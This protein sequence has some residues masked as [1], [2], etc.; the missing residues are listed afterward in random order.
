MKTLLSVLLFSSFC[1]ATPLATATSLDIK[2]KNAEVE[3]SVPAEAKKALSNWNPEFVVFNLKD[4]G[5]SVLDLFKEI[6]PKAVPVA[7]IADLN[8]DGTKD[9][10]LLGS[11]LQRQ[12]AVALLE[13]NKVWTAIEVHSW[14]IP[15]IK[16]TALN[17]ES[18][19]K[20]KET[21]I[22]IYILPAEGEHAKKLGKKIGIQVETYLG[23]AEVYEIK[24]G[25]AVKF[26]LK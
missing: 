1:H 10:V 7:F 15:N 9:I 17:T 4:Y 25:K 26:V 21:G 20:E 3:I 23:P 22:P 6:D 24:D 14:S 5:K 19:S 16:T 11:D 13:K 12:Y 18:T 2:V 8:S